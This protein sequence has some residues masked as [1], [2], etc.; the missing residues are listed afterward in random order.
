MEKTITITSNELEHSLETEVILKEKLIKAGYN[1][2]KKIEK[3]TELIISIGGDGSFLQSVHKFKFSDIPIMAINTGHLGFFAEIY[4]NE[5]D[6][7]I[8]KY[9]NGKYSLQQACPV[10]ASIYTE[11]DKIDILAI[12]EIAIK[13]DKSRTLHLRLK[14]NGVKMQCFSGDGMLISTPMGSTAYNYSAG[15][16]IV[17]PSLN[18]YQL[19]PICP[20]NTNAYRSFT[21]SIILPSNSIINILPENQFEDN[22]L[23]IIDGIERKFKQIEE[24]KIFKSDIKINLLRLEGYEFWERVSEKFL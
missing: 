9:R 11:K 2:S 24:I 3:D 8:Y 16:C 5:I 21:S 22:I 14:V 10:K 4:P 23:L 17:D 7:F 15:G 12:N 6:E 1:V 19:T 18:L 20:M 13:N